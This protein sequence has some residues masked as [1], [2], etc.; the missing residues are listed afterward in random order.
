MNMNNWE[1]ALCDAGKF[2]L[3]ICNH[4]LLL[5]DAIHHGS[6]R[7]PI[8]PASAALVVD[9]AYKLSETAREMFG[10]TLTAHD[11]QTLIRSLL[12]SVIHRQRL[13]L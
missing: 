12:P 4:N 3:Q 9:E 7:K 8:L 2:L 5:A 13:P 11:I 10:T 1:I 6:G